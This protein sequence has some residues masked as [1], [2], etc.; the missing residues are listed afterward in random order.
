MSED[1]SIKFWW[2]LKYH[3]CPWAN[4][5]DTNI[6]IWIY[7]KVVYIYIW[8][9]LGHLCSYKWLCQIYWLMGVYGTSKLRKFWRTDFKHVAFG[10][11]FKCPSKIHL[12]TQ[13]LEVRHHSNATKVFY[14]CS[15]LFQLTHGSRYSNQATKW[16]IHSS[17]TILSVTLLI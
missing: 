3:R 13:C 17:R 5:F 8:S 9:F 15:S 10:G 11:G 2:F 14:M 4:T 12:N 7:I 6:F 1:I 16:K